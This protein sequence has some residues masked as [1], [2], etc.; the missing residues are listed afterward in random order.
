MHIRFGAALA[1]STFALASAT[2]AQAQYGVFIADVIGQTIANMNQ[3][4]TVSAC[5]NGVPNTD[6]EVEEARIPSSAT[7]ASVAEA[8][9]SG[10]A[11]TEF[12]V[13]DEPELIVSGQ[14]LS[15]LEPT[16]LLPEGSSLDAEPLRFFR[17]GLQATAVGQWGAT[18]ADGGHAAILTGFF[19]RKG[20]KW[21]LQ[22]LSVASGDELVEP[23]AQF[24]YEPGD[25]TEHRITSSARQRENLVKQVENAEQRLER[26]RTKLAESREKA[27][28][29]RPTSGRRR[30]VVQDQR[31]VE[32]WERKLE[33]RQEWLE[34]AIEAETDAMEDAAQ[35]KTLTLPVSEAPSAWAAADV[36]AAAEEAAELAA[37]EAEDAAASAEE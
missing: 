26:A 1:A 37:Q 22:S 34:L 16:T 33:Q 5:M 19:R 32:D 23:V 31:R 17:S 8:S 12:F 7:I 27:A 20:G 30:R 13:D 11:I 9:Q 3:Q 35:L 21:K 24:C 18:G 6:A 25:V 14:A 15:L 2:P 29:S 4:G 28:D 36:E 10:T